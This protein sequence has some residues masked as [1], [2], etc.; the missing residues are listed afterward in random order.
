MILNALAGRPLPVYGRA[1]RARLDPRGGPLPRASSPPLERGRAGAVYNFGGASERRN[2][3]VVR[4][5]RGGGRAP[6]RRSSSSSPTAR[7]T[8]GATPSTS[9]G[10]SE[11]LDW[12]PSRSFETGL[13]ETVAWYLAHRSWWERV[14]D[15]A[16]LKSAEMIRSWAAPGAAGA[17]A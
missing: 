2:L 3:D 1:E 13:R 5:H 16:Y 12:R 6:P 10:A 4:A 17:G 11:A 14:Q 9:P 8:T 7:A 15:G